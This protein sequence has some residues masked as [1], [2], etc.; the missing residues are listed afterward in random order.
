[1]N[2]AVPKSGI[3]PFDFGAAFFKFLFELLLVEIYL[4]INPRTLII[5]QSQ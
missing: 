3:K 5:G 4:K 2:K 1:M